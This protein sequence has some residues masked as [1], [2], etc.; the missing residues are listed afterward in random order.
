MA[1][2][3][4]SPVA[5]PHGG[6]AKF[7]A[8]LPRVL[9]TS[10]LEGLGWRKPNLLTLLVPVFGG[11]HQADEYLLRLGFEFYSEWP[12]TATFVNPKT[13]RF[14]AD[15]DLYWLPRI[16][17]DPGLAVHAK[18][19]ATGSTSQ[20]ICCSFT[21]QFYQV[22][23]SVQP[24]HVWNAEHFTFGATIHRIQRALQSAYYRGR[25]NPELPKDA[26]A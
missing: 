4:V 24:E 10:T 22:L 17:G 2:A 25:M 8:H 5:D 9:G 3:G 13:L 6:R 14:D 21:A 12:P 19:Q 11:P 1:K 23:H 15:R 20:L 18:Y 16:E 26:A 7:E